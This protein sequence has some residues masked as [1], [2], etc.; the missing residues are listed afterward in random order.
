[1]RELLTREF[2][3]QG[4]LFWKIAAARNGGDGWDQGFGIGG[5]GFFGPTKV[6]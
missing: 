5:D 4:S 6:M 1:M 2:C 3:M